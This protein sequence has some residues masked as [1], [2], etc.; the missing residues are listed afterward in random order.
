MAFRLL[1]VYL[2]GKI[3]NA[4]GEEI[5]IKTD[6]RDLLSILFCI[7]FFFNYYCFLREGATKEVFKSL[8]GYLA[9]ESMTPK[10]KKKKSRKLNKNY[11][12][13]EGKSGPLSERQQMF[14]SKVEA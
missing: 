10:K 12:Q 7:F 13:K 9:F 11:M 8:L 4:T 5:L 14:N 3:K 1:V 2:V 6:G